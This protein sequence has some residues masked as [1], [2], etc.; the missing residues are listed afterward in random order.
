MIVPVAVPL[1][2]HRPYRSHCKSSFCLW[3]YQYVRKKR[4]IY[5]NAWSNGLVW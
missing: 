3:V 5:S 1:L 2:I 4:S